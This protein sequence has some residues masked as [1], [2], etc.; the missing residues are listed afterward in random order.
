MRASSLSCAV[1]RRAITGAIAS[2]VR[3][4]S[5]AQTS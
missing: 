1:A 3:S 5:G 2:M 4:T